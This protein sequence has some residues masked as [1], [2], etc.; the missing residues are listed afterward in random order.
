MHTPRNNFGLLLGC[1]LGLVF[2]IPP[3]DAANFDFHFGKRDT[4]HRLIATLLCDDS[5]STSSLRGESPMPQRP[6]R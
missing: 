6:T 5:T 4:K 1:L 2:F 3:T